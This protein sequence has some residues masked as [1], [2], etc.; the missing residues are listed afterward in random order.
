MRIKAAVLGATGLVG[1]RFVSLLA[2]HPWFDLVALTASEKRVGRSYGEVVEWVIGEDVPDAVKDLQVLPNDLKVLRREGVEVAFSALPSSV[3][4]GVEESLLKGGITVVSNASPMRL[5]PD[6]P[7][8]NPEVNVS[9]LEVLE[10]QKR[11]GWSGRLVKVPNCSTAILTLALKPLIDVYRVR[12]VAVTTMQA[13]S[14]AGLRGVPGYM[15]G[16]N[17]IPF[18]KGEEEKLTAESAKILGFV[19]KDSIRPSEVR[20]SASCTRVPVLDG[21]LESVFVD[22]D[23]SVN[24]S[25]VV[26]VLKSFRGEIAGWGL[27]TAPENPVVVRGEEWRPQPRLDVM[28][29]EGMSVVVGRVRVDEGDRLLKFFVLGHNTLRGA[30]GSGVLIGEAMVK[31]GLL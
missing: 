19:D 12:R 31:K 6:I 3:A 13:I 1:Q 24:P 21:H 5:E 18:I 14:G 28:A 10:K 20:V 23:E 2:N 27:P 15:I 8:L 16:C 11:R 22:L 4:W 25:E 17:V 26:K 7:L 9:H 30:A 29:G